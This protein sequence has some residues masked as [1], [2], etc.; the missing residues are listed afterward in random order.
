MIE[1]TK[2]QDGTYDV[3]PNASGGG[4]T[5]YAW[6]MSDG[7][8]D[9]QGVMYFNFDKAPADLAELNQK[10]VFVININDSGSPYIIEAYP[11]LISAMSVE[12]YTRTD[13]DTMAFS[14]ITFTRQSS[15]DFTMW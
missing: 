2:L 9:E 11:V 8:Q 3:N 12:S 7:G 5:S 6:H 13:D 14:G 15:K 4:A 1:V 10:K